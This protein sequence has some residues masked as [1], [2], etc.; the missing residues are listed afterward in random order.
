MISQDLDELRTISDRLLVIAGGV[1]TEAGPTGAVSTETIGLMMAGLMT[2]GVREMA[3]A[4]A[5]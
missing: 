2:D 1:L 4:T 3:H 5:D